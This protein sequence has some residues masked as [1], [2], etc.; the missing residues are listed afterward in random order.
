MGE[1]QELA[2]EITFNRSLK[3]ESRAERLTGDAGVLLLRELDDRLGLSSSLGESLKDCREQDQAR[4]SLTELLRQRLYGYVQGYRHQ[5]DMDRTARERVAG[6]VRTVDVRMDAGF[7]IGRVLDGLTE[8]GTR[9]VRR[10]RGNAVLERMAEP[11]LTRPVGRPP[12]EGYEFNL[13]LGWYQAEDWRH[14][15]RVVLVVVDRPDPKTGQL[16]LWPD[17]FF[18]V[19]NWTQEQRSGDELLEHYRQR[20]T[21]EDRL[22][23]IRDAVRPSLSSPRF[24]ENEATLLMVLLAHNL[25]GMIRG[26][27]EEETGSGWDAA[28][29]RDTVLKTGGR[30]AKHSHR[31]IP[32]VAQAVTPLWNLLDRALRRLRTRHSRPSPRRKRA[33]VPPPS[34][35]HLSLVLRQ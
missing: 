5:D 15:Q 12:Q 22:A 21:F 20:G 1:E 3:A 2:F 6:L 18:L 26:L 30:I 11:Y 29:V 33:W 23:E 13:E 9:F 7:T 4:Y 35:T 27:L 34:H 10:L 14:A 17:H 25:L 31:L 24:Q 28:R 19:T 32:A 16:S 8:D